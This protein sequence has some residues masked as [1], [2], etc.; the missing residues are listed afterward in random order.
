M[1]CARCS[2][3]GSK[4]LAGTRYNSAPS[5][6]MVRAYSSGGAPSRRCCHH[7]RSSRAAREGSISGAAARRTI[8]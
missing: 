5:A 4:R 6:A 8:A 2:A 1:A 3:E 7:S